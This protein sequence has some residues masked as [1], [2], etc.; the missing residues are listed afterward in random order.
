MFRGREMIGREVAAQVRSQIRDWIRVKAM[1]GFSEWDSNCYAAENVMSLLNVFD[2]TED[3]ELRGEA[4]SL[5]DLICFGM[6]ANSCKGVYASSHGR[7][8]Q[9]LDHAK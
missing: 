1:V 6:A 4:R 9:R 2:F 8:L 3:E 7:T 5:L